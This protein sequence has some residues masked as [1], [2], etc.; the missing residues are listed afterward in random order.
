MAHSLFGG[1]DPA[2]LADLIGD[3]FATWVKVGP[4]GVQDAQGAMVVNAPVQTVYG[5]CTDYERLHTF[6]SL[7]KRSKYKRLG[8]GLVDV[9]FRQRVG[10][11]IFSVGIDLRYELRL[12]PPHSVVS[13]RY[14][15]GAFTRSE[16]GAFFCP[17][18]GDRTLLVMRFTGDLDAI[19]WLSRS[20]FSRV[21][22]LQPAVA[23]NMVMVPI[24][25]L[26]SEAERRSGRARIPTPG[27]TLSDRLDDAGL[28]PALKEGVLTVG[29]LAP[30]GA[31]L[32]AC[33][34]ARFAQPPETLWPWVNELERLPRLVSFVDHGR[35]WDDSQGRRHHEI[36]Y[37][38]SFGPLKKRYKLN[39][40]TVAEPPHRLT[41][42]EADTDGVA[43]RYEDRI[44]ADGTGSRYC[45]LSQFDLRRDWLTKKFLAS[46]SELERLIGTYPSFVRVQTLYSHLA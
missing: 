13:E 36:G 34:A 24:T 35:S 44:A 25:G 30:D 37:K 26:A 43:T 15:K 39:L 9:T 1:S 41:A 12:D 20:F 40:T 11:A 4:N 14:V 45:H 29:R 19:G 21:P 23:G 31:V 5:A 38:V 10:L 42:V 3:G 6:L 22:E 2:Y 28:A 17:L 16:Y 7:S 18:D 46:H 33:T 8:N 27:T 32:D